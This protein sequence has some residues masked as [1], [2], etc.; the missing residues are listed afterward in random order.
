MKIGFSSPPALFLRVLS[1]S[2]K[3]SL[4]SL[5]G[6]EKKNSPLGDRHESQ[7]AR[8]GSKTLLPLLDASNM[9][10]C[11][12]DLGLVPAC[13]AGVLRYL[14]VLGLRV[15]RMPA[16]GEGC[17]AAEKGGAAEFGDPALY[18]YLSVASPST[19]DMPPLRAWW[20]GAGAGAGAADAR[21]A[22]G[23]RE[24]F[25][26]AA[27]GRSGA[28]PAECTPDLAASIVGSHAH[29][30]AMLAVFALQDVLAMSSEAYRGA[31]GGDADGSCGGDPDGGSSPPPPPSCYSR[32]PPPPGAESINDPSV[33]RHY[34]RWRCHAS[35]EEMER[36]TSMTGGL[37]RM[38]ESA[39]RDVGRGGGRRGGGGKEEGVAEAT[40]AVARVAIR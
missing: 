10:V 9:L 2:K 27:L 20:E 17:V 13:A 7:W 37:R 40:A 31:S 28:P 30:P 4:L 39:G 25:W 5:S 1:R 29:S 26:R 32:P 6:E 14:G 21:R 12:E 11:G 22:Q 19:H 16:R 33:R 36:D 8:H 34:W 35:V 24:R 23:L 3:N 15:Q 18:P 38:L